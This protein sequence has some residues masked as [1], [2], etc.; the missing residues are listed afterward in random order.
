MSKYYK[1]KKEIK[2]IIKSNNKF[3]VAKIAQEINCGVTVLEK[4]LDS[5]VEIDETITEKLSNKLSYFKEKDKKDNSKIYKLLSFIT[6][7]VLLL[8]VI[9]FFYFL[10]INKNNNNVQDNKPYIEIVYPEDLSVIDANLLET[11]GSGDIYLDT[12]LKLENLPKDHYISIVMR[13]AGGDAFWISGNSISTDYC[14]NK[15]MIG[16]ITFG[17]I[18]DDNEKF[19]MFA[20]VTNEALISGTTYNDLPEYLV[21]SKKCFVTIKKNKN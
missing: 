17:K 20:I 6:I 5:S 1:I 8:F 2:K 19:E 15:E 4:W 10:I 3:I 14:E 13:V 7:P 12:E 9:I 11:T 21:R 16:Y 18:D